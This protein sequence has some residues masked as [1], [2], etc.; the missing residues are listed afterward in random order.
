[1]GK[2]SGLSREANIVRNAG[3]MANRISE[4]KLAIMPNL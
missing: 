1:M 4:T 2:S 3:G